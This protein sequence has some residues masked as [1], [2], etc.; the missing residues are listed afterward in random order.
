[1]S[2]LRYYLFRRPSQ[3]K[4][5]ELSENHSPSRNQG[6]PAPLSYNRANGRLCVAQPAAIEEKVLVLDWSC[7][8]LFVPEGWRDKVLYP[9]KQLSPNADFMI[10]F[11]VAALLLDS[12]RP[13][14]RAQ[15]IP[16]SHKCV[17]F[18]PAVP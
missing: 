9:W 6:K 7:Y 15:S 14:S 16:Q 8:S 11:R 12:P 17:P 5:R 3:L 1:M 2:N 13:V 18:C 4:A 10:L